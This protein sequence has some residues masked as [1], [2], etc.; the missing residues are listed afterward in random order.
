MSYPFFGEDLL[1]RGLGDV[2][3][4][5]I[6]EHVWDSI[7]PEDFQRVAQW[8]LRGVPS[9]LVHTRIMVLTLCGQKLLP[10]TDKGLKPNDSV[11]AIPKRADK[12]LKP[13]D[14]VFA[15]PKSAEKASL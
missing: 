4:I 8:D 7:V 11:F 10:V 12:G 15:I 6:P 9:P 5:S 13:N 3:C 1:C 14:S 2:G